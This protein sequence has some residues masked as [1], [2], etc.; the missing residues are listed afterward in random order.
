MRWNR[1]S[2]MAVMLIVD[3]NTFVP[4]TIGTSLHTASPS[5]HVGIETCVI[6]TASSSS[7]VDG[8]RVLMGQEEER[9]QRRF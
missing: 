8:Q 1:S 2:A 9:R 5:F 6:I 3:T 7:L 4:A